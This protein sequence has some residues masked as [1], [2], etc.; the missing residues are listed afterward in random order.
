MKTGNCITDGTMPDKW[1]NGKIEPL[2]AADGIRLMEDEPTFCEAARVLIGAKKGA[3]FA[4][5]VYDTVAENYFDPRRKGQKAGALAL[6]M[7]AQR[8]AYLTRIFK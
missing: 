5:W 8:Q 1:L 3:G 7:L 6:A 4:L 2:T